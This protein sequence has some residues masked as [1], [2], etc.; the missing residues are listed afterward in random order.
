MRTKDEMREH[1]S[2]IAAAIVYADEECETPWE[3]F[4]HWDKD[5]L[6]E[7]QEAIAQSIFDG[8]LWVQ[9]GEKT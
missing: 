8:M 5:N 6:D 3:P 9:D 4:E 7:M 1:A 2:G